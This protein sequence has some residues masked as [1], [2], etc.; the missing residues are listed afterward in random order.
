VAISNLLERLFPAV[1]HVSVLGE[2]CEN[3]TS[4]ECLI[5]VRKLV[6][7]PVP[8]LKKKKSDSFTKKLASEVFSNVYV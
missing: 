7:V 3:R 1:Q 2:E 5:H 8:N 6:V 4:P